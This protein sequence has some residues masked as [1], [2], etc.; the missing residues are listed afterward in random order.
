MDVCS[1]LLKSHASIFEEYLTNISE[2][3]I[4]RSRL[5]AYILNRYHKTFAYTYTHA[6][7]Y[8]YLRVYI[9]SLWSCTVNSVTLLVTL[10]DTIRNFD[11]SIDMFFDRKLHYRRCIFWSFLL[12]QIFWLLKLYNK[13]ELHDNL[14][15]HSIA[16]KY[17][18][19]LVYFSDILKILTNI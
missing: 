8:T 6:H 13:K 15:Q 2:I 11:C 18:L 10:L 1:S 17:H 4:E 19:L 7:E 5:S 14:F 3:I 12:D 9:H 16:L